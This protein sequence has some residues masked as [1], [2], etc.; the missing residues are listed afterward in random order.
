LRSI[1]SMTTKRFEDLINA[2]RDGEPL[3]APVSDAH[4]SVTMLL[5][6]N[7]AWK[8][9]RTLH[10]NKQDVHILNAPPSHVDVGA[11]I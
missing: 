8:T 1:D 3:H 11:G 4:I 5:L 9:D 6:S 7:I 2:I 10:L